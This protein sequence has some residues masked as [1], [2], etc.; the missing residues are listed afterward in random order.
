[1]SGFRKYFLLTCSLVCCKQK[2]QR[3]IGGRPHEAVYPYDSY[4]EE[5]ES[6]LRRARLSMWLREYILRFPTATEREIASQIPKIK[7]DDRKA[8]QEYAAALAQ[9]RARFPYPCLVSLNKVETT[10]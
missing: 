5:K 1:M 8:P 9:Q 3:N 6:V 2:K 7:E 10:A 4:E